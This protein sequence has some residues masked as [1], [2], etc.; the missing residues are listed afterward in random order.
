MKKV[1]IS[2]LLAIAIVIPTATTEAA[3]V[4]EFR[5]VA[6]NYANYIGTQR[7]H[8]GFTSYDYNCD[9]NVGDALVQQYMQF[10]TSYY[11]FYF[12][13]NDSS[14]LRRTANSQ[15]IFYFYFGYN[16]PTYAPPVTM[17]KSK[18]RNSAYCH[19]AV[20]IQHYYAQGYARVKIQVAN[21]LSYG[22]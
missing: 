17:G 22:G 4:P 1:L 16:G 20:V 18:K 10:L 7:S 5:Q 14:D 3:D 12:I 8:Y 21:G 6:G 9:L 2:F 19:V 15:D 11:P 13:G